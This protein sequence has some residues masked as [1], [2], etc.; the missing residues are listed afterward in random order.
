MKILKL[1]TYDYYE[2]EEPFAV[3][4][5]E[6]ALIAEYERIK[7]EG[8]LLFSNRPLLLNDEAIRKSGSEE[9]F[10]TIEDIKQV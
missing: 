2:W 5:N 9:P 6:D 4:E 7:S 8:V 3:S 1:Y 10:W